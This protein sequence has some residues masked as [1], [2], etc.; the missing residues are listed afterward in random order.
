M[1]KVVKKVALTGGGTAGHIWPTLAVAKEIEKQNPKIKFIYIG[2]KTGL[3]AKII[4]GTKY[5]FYGISTGKLRRYFSWQNFL[6][7]FQ[8][9]VGFFQALKILAREKPDAIFAKGGYVTVPVVLAGWFSKIPAIIHESDSILGLANKFLSRFA[10]K[11]TTAFPAKYY[12]PK[13]RKKIFWSGLPIGEEFFKAEKNKAF[14]VFGLSDKLPI[15]LVFGGS[16]GAA[17][18]NYL[19]SR[20]LKNL[21]EKCQLI[22]ITGSRDFEKMSKKQKALPAKL[23]ERYKVFEFL[24]KEMPLVFKVAD[25]IVSRCGAN[26]L[27][28]IAALKKASILIPLPTSAGNHQSANAR[29]FKESRAAMVLTE[30]KIKPPIL[31]KKISDLISRSFLLK[32]LGERAG[33]FYKPDAAKILAREILKLS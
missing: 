22:H 33:R 16:Q 2:S 8:V 23:K 21:L 25:L 9:L 4:P 32:E 15:V 27:A 17:K 13:Y 19:V 28:E 18:I 7:P 14:Q 30:D 3:E 1:Q 10:R 6:M 12:R 20:I 29:I 31:A 26:S 11:I 5:K 24:S